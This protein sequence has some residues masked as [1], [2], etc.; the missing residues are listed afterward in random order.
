MSDTLSVE[1][2]GWG[3]ETC[4]E[5]EDEK[6]DTHTH[7]KKTRLLPYRSHTEKGKGLKW[8]GEEIEGVRRKES[9]DVSRKQGGK[10]KEEEKKK[11]PPPEQVASNKK[12]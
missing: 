11:K 1:G 8:G 6:Q 12:S 9:E 4:D 5:K 3:K 10:G 2:G 7:K